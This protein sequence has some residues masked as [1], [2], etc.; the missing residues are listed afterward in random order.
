MRE[1]GTESLRRE[2]KGVFVRGV[3]DVDVIFLKREAT[4][5]RPFVCPYAYIYL[6]LCP[7]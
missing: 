5:V 1:R 4:F 7:M 3:R 2:S 6:K